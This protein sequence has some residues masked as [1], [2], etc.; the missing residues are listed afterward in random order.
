M[1]LQGLSGHLPA[2]DGTGLF[3]QVWEAYEPKAWVLALH[4]LAAHGG[5]YET[6]AGQ[7]LR[8]AV[9]TVAVDLRGHGLTKWPLAKLP[10]PSQATDDVRVAAVAL[11][12]RAE[13]LPVYGMGT[14]LG[15]AVLLHALGRRGID[16]E[17][18]VLLSPA[19][20]QI[21]IPMGEMI[22]IG[23]GLVFGRMIGFPTPLGRG[24]T[25]TTDQR[26]QREL[27]DDKLA[28]KELPSL[29]WL[30]AARI[31][32][33]GKASLSRVTSPLLV[34]QARDDEVIDARENARLFE[35]RAGVTWAWWKG[36]HDVKLSPAVDGVAGMISDWISGKPAPE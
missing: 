13:G 33:A 11:R 1:Q 27:L 25:L 9:S 19:I 2:S 35:H 34:I 10:S 3:Y 31:M 4:G 29:A 28:L 14:S 26:R 36:G 24:L 15:A 30:Q 21:F 22:R 18:A 7:L 5:W 12:A 6:L 23:V 32:A 8:R 16:L 20:R 17:G